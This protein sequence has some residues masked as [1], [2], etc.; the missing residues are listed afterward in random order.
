MS[1]GTKRSSC[2]NLSDLVVTEA[3]KSFELNIALFDEVQRLSESGQLVR[4]K[5]AK[6]SSSL[7]QYA[8]YALAATATAAVVGAVVYHRYSRR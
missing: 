7:R 1:R 3:I 4:T 8:P 2:I 5:G 6:T